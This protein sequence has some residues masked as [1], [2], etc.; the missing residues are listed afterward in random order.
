MT[1][2]HVQLFSE[3]HPPAGTTP[4]PRGDEGD[5]PAQ[6]VDAHHPTA[7]EIHLTLFS[8]R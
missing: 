4:L 3:Q 2:Q 7:T 1:H 5:E 8:D 6:S